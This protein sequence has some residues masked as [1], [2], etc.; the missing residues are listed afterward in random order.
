MKSLRALAH[1]LRD[2]SGQAL[3]EQGILLTTLLGIGAV[4]GLWLV[5]AHPDMLKALDIAMRSYLFV[6]SLPFP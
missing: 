5:K 2:E 6:L 1:L 4:G 3:T